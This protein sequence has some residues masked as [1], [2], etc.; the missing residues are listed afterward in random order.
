MQIQVD[1]QRRSS[2]FDARISRATQAPTWVYSAAYCFAPNSSRMADAT[3]GL[4]AAGFIYAPTFTD[5]DPVGCRASE[6]LPLCQVP[7]R[8]HARL[9]RR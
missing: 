2:Y 8:R 9:R 6:R 5:V 3:R 7:D 4:R 1:E